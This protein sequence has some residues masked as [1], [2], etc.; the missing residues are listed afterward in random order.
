MSGGQGNDTLSSYGYKTYIYG[1]EGNDSIEISDFWDGLAEVG[2]DGGEGDDT[3]TV[4]G[5]VIAGIGVEGGDEVHVGSDVVLLD[6]YVTSTWTGQISREGAAWINGFSLNIFTQGI[7]LDLSG[8]GD[9]F[10]DRIF[11]RA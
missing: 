10:G 1:G 4:D 2:A 8:L 5:F 7:P 3:F 6:L 9:S 11:P